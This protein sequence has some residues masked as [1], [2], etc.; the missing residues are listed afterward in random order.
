VLFSPSHAI[1]Q[2]CCYLRLINWAALARTGCGTLAMAIAAIAIG[3][4]SGLTEVAATG[5]IR[6][7]GRF[8]DWTAAAVVQDG[9]VVCY[10][11]THVRPVGQEPSNEDEA[12]FA[13]S[14]DDAPED[15]IAVGIDN[16]QLKDKDEVTVRVGRAKFGF[17]MYDGSAF[18][19]NNDAVIAA[20]KR[21][22]AAYV[23]SNADRAVGEWTFSLDGFTAAY[24]AEKKGCKL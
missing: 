4:A 9:K 20:F 6:S 22:M 19:V 23:S 15:S 16:D 13:I 5:T 17:F 21:G 2:F 8:N 11:F 18:A 7:L 14:R 24:L 10:A 3:L 1:H 12:A